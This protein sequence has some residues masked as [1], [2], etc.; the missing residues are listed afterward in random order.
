M[1][2]PMMSTGTESSEFIVFG[3]C[4]TIFLAGNRGHFIPYHEEWDRFNQAD[5]STRLLA[6][7]TKRQI[8]LPIKSTL[9]L[10]LHR[11]I[12]LNR[13]GESPQSI[14]MRSSWQIDPDWDLVSIWSSTEKTTRETRCSQD[15]A[16]SRGSLQRLHVSLWYCRSS[17]VT[18]VIFPSFSWPLRLSS[19]P[20]C[21]DISVSLKN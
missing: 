5:I 20:C 2:A 9:T 6:F 18:A 11:I 3:C 16:P 8:E 14:R 21:Y 12:V 7:M 15:S 17:S 4:S 13:E 19:L 10:L 1:P